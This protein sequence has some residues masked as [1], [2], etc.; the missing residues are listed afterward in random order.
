VTIVGDRVTTEDKAEL[1]EAGCQVER[2][3]GDAYALEKA[4]ARLLAD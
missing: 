4:F 2:L 1:I 3:S